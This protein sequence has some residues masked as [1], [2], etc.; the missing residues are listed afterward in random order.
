[1]ALNTAQATVIKRGITGRFDLG[2]GR[3]NNIFYPR[4]ATV[5][6]S[7]GADE[8]YGFM[9]DM[10]G[11]R[12]WV[13]DRIF[14][15]LRAGEYRIQNKTWEDSLKIDRHA[16]DDDRLRMY[17]PYLENL[18]AEAAMHPDELLFDTILAGETDLGF[19]GLAFFSTSHV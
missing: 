18:G 8:N 19:D 1:V 4:I 7:D 6:P 14:K 13:G 15:E 10:P 2:F 17:G 16:L 12:E 9:G 11:V 5:M 3:V